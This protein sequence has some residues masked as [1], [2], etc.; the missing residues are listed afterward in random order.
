[1]LATESQTSKP[2]TKSKEHIFLADP[3]WQ[4]S[5]LQTQRGM[6]AMLSSLYVFVHSANQKG[7]V[8]E[9]N[10]L[11]FLYSIT[12][13]PPAIRACKSLPS[14]DIVFPLLTEFTVAIIL[15]NRIPLPQEQAA[16]S[17]VLYHAAVDFVVRAPVQVAGNP[18]R[19]F[20]AVSNTPCIVIVI[21]D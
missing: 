11:A 14:L 20:E 16:L 21:K 6:A 8:G 19:F 13:F 7:S 9:A 5:V 4:P 3:A 1:M 10:I 15:G 12:R 18:S 17:V 2:V